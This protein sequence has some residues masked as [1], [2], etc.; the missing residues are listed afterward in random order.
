M[1]VF[2]RKIAHLYYVVLLSTGLG[3]NLQ[4]FTSSLLG[5]E[6]NKGTIERLQGDELNITLTY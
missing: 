6:G 1:Y 3:D 4:D 2:W 5:W